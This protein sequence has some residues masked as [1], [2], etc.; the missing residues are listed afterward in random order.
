MDK[1]DKIIEQNINIPVNEIPTDRVEY[2]R[3]LSGLS[4]HLKDFIRWFRNSKIWEDENG[5]IGINAGG[6]RIYFYLGGGLYARFQ[7]HPS[8]T[9]DTWDYLQAEF[10]TGMGVYGGSFN[11]GSATE[12]FPSTHPNAGDLVPYNTYKIRLAHAIYLYKSGTTARLQCS[13]DGND[14]EIYAPT[15]VKIFADFEATGTKAFAIPHPDGSDRKLRYTA[16]ESPEVLLRHRGKGILDGDNNYIILFPPHFM[17]VTEPEGLVT[18]N[19]TPMAPNADLYVDSINSNISAK[20][21]GARQ[22]IDFF[23]EVIAVRKGYLDYQC[24][25]PNS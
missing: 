17:A 15:K 5:Y 25:I 16:Q 1:K 24:E 13:S 18:I 4:L 14:V 8:T 7:K 20:I 6:E 12:V 19:L 11:I 21:K 9:H 10:Y 23:Y 3:K 2:K 22:G